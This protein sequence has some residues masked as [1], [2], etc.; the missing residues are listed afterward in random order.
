[1]DTNM[2]EE[3]RLFSASAFSDGIEAKIRSKLTTFIDASH[4]AVDTWIYK[5]KTRHQ[6]PESEAGS[7]QAQH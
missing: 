3:N 5:P 1:M 2:H 7:S 4:W 6:K